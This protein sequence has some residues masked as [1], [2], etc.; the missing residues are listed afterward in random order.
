MGKYRQTIRLY[1]AH[2]LDLITFMETHEFNITR[3]IYCALTAFSKNDY[4]VIDIPPKR[5]MELNINKK[6]Y[7]KQLSL[8]T[9]KDSTAIEILLKIKRGG[10]NNFLK[11]L[12]RSYLCN[13]IAES[14]LE[15][16]E[17]IK[18]FIKKFEVMK[19]SRRHASAGDLHLIRH[20]KKKKNDNKIKNNATQGTK[21]NKGTEEI[22][23]QFEPEHNIYIE[24]IASNTENIIQNI[25]NESTSDDDEIMNLFSALI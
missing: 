19:Q 10:R 1:R 9:E 2:D 18:D 3:A 25:D 21:I 8:D 23:T 14:Y 16:E 11:N 17:D 5:E 12:L 13:P 24:P 4:F 6:V 22:K 20:S 15:N 7:A